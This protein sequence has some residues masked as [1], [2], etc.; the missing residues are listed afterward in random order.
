MTKKPR[1]TIG[2]VP[3]WCA[4]DAIVECSELKPNLKNPNTHP[5]K[6]IALL[7]KIITE[8][9]WRMPITVSKRSGL[10]VK[11][12]G[13][14]EAAIKAGIQKAP[15]DYQDYESEAVEHADMV[16]D[17][18]LAELAV[19]DDDKLS[20]LLVELNDFEIDMD[21]TGFDVD[22]LNDFRGLVDAPTNIPDLV[23]D[24]DPNILVRLSFHPGLYLGKREEIRDILDK[25]AATY[26]CII[27]V[28]E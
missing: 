22:D 9:G 12:H 17:T 13:R 3:V 16:A 26:K 18:R 20:G 2:D 8:Q 4:H 27:K 24:K 15:V 11:G 23:P 5:K 14:L 19:I 7:G 1:A 28:E 10:I 25:M 21:L 6:Q